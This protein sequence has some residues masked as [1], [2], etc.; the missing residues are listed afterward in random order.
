MPKHS[1]TRS[2]HDECAVHGH[3]SIHIVHAKNNQRHAVVMMNVRCM[4][5]LLFPITFHGLKNNS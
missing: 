5:T 3:S 2:R 1:T 4:D